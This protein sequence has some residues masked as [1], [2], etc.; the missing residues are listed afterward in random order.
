MTVIQKE[1]SFAMNGKKS[2]EQAIRDMDKEI[3][4]LMK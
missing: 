1:V 3:K 4:A 2:P